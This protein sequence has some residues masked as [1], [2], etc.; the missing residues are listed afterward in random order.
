MMLNVGNTQHNVNAQDELIEG[1]KTYAGL[2]WHIFPVH[3]ANKQPL[4]DA[5]QVKASTDPSRIE[6]WWGKWPTAM[7]GVVC[8][9]LS[10]IAVVD[11]DGEEGLDTLEALEMEHGNLGEIPEA[12]TPRGGAHLYFTSESLPFP[13]SESRIAPKIDVRSAAPDG[14]GV[15]YAILPPSR[16]IDGTAYAWNAT[17]ELTDAPAWLAFRACFNKDERDVI[18]ANKA[19]SGLIE[20]SPRQEWRTLY[21]A[22]QTNERAFE[23]AGREHGAKVNGKALTLD[24]PY[25][26][27]A[28]DKALKQLTECR[29]AQNAA[30][31]A[32]AW[33][34]ARLL[35]GAGVAD[36]EALQQ[37][38]LRLLDAA[39]KFPVLDPSE[40]WTSREGRERARNTIESGLKAGL[41]NPRDL[42]Q[43]KQ[44]KQAITSTALATYTTVS[45]PLSSY[46]ETKLEWLWPGWIPKGK[47][48]V[49]G[50]KTKVGKS[51]FAVWVVARVTAGIPFPSSEF[52]GAKLVPQR[53]R[54]IL[55]TAEDDIGDTV[56][57]RV[58]VAR[59]NPELIHI[60]DG[61]EEQIEGDKT[62]KRFSFK[63]AKEALAMLLS[64]H[65]G[66][67]GI[68]VVDPVNAYQGKIDAHRNNEVRAAMAPLKELAEEYGVPVLLIHHTKK[69]PATEGD[70]TD[71]FG[72]S[73]ATVEAARSIIMLA[74]EPGDTGRYIIEMVKGNRAE[75]GQRYYYE[76]VRDRTDL[77]EITKFVLVE[78]GERPQTSV[79]E[80]MRG[81]QAG[82]ATKM[83]R[84]MELLE[85]CLSRG[86]CAALRS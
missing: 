35:A 71:Q 86:Q 81:E 79:A 65:P 30:L 85:E 40:P 76:I 59:G 82:D 37:T 63:R 44:G 10:G 20:E 66:E 36:L 48:T 25:I 21:E 70:V 64:Q 75:G 53:K 33:S 29:D 47:I 43:L 8:G 51:Q 9:P 12:L 17:P 84:A 83:E 38:K 11:V 45:R 42:S 78:K 39:M 3:P 22:H 41:K 60:V 18:G 5:W 74:K 56:V 69:G 14:K 54:A 46:E 2:G 24:H 34:I 32:T 27:A 57:P 55:L 49:A 72:G 28:I 73:N 13:K 80:A 16:R 1:A 23:A 4:I 19:L 50:G 62:R 58:K 15:G 68:I 31:N 7:I 52:G 77:N 6:A 26:A 61:Y 67:F